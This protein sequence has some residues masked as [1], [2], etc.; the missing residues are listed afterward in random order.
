M[1]HGQNK[2]HFITDGVQWQMRPST[3]HSAELLLAGR[4]AC[5]PDVHIGWVKVRNSF[6]CQGRGEELPAV[7]AV[8]WRTAEVWVPRVKHW[9]MFIF[10]SG[11]SACSRK[12]RTKCRGDDSR[13]WQGCI[14]AVRL[15][16]AVW[17]VA[18]GAAFLLLAQ[19]AAAST[20]GAWPKMAT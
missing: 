9:R 13:Q 10:S 19:G 6:W 14:P 8:W 18:R 17:A 20:H 15:H 5:C 12:P 3:W 11:F 2:V 16:H 7:A 1:W 4:A